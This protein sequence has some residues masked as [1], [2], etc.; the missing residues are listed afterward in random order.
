[1]TQARQA[2]GTTDAVLNFIAALVFGAL[3]P[4]GATVA[5]QP[6]LTG[7]S[8]LFDV[9]DVTTVVV[10]LVAGAVTLLPV[11][12]RSGWI[13][14]AIGIAGEAALYFQDTGL[15]RSELI[16]TTAVVVGLQVG[17]AVLA[18]TAAGNARWP[19][20]LGIGVGLVGGRYLLS[21]L[22]LVV[23]NDLYIHTQHGD[24]II[25]GVLALV[26]AAAGVVPLLRRTGDVSAD[27]SAPPI[28][29]FVPVTVAAVVARV[30]I[31]G[32]RQFLNHYAEASTGGMSSASVSMIQTMDQVAHVAIAAIATTILAVA[33][34]RR[35]G[36]SLARWVLVVFAAVPVLDIGATGSVP[37]AI[38]VLRDLVF[39]ALVG[40]AFGAYLV[41]LNDRR[42]PWDALGVAGLLAGLLLVRPGRLYQMPSIAVGVTMIAVAL[43]T[44]TLATGLAR[45]G[46]DGPGLDG[47]AAGGSA[48]LG[49]A[50]LVICLPIIVPVMRP[51]L[52]GF[53]DVPVA[54]A[55]ALGVTALL[56]V[57]LF[58]RGS[59]AAAASPVSSV[60]A[61]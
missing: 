24:D 44:F 32:W 41:R 40:V 47:G 26:V 28:W 13:L 27:V 38:T 21:Y 9:S 3:L 43:L 16:L 8:A 4:A 58:L 46:G 30:L 60:E 36:P 18:L 19:L 1:M 56:L 53:P 22:I 61:G 35:G 15:D 33:A 45:L 31:A 11:P 25:L 20:L 12:R 7:S 42:A 54:G 37:T 2:S 34:Y 14:V 5:M 29:P 52:G 10:L 55:V 17:G 23:R 48:A 59:R 57:V 6:S 49:L 51:G 39:P 50:A